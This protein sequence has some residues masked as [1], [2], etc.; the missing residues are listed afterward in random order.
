MAPLTFQGL[1]QQPEANDEVNAGAAS[2][3]SD[4]FQEVVFE[5]NT[6]RKEAA[7]YSVWLCQRQGGLSHARD[8]PSF[9]QVGDEIPIRTLERSSPLKKPKKSSSFFFFFPRRTSN[10]T[11]SGR[12]AG[13][14]TVA[15][16]HEQIF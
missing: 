12:A 7:D 11:R 2:S 6:V 10:V 16:S 13:E 4:F 1:C 3:S 5:M 8:K 14:T 9:P 15:V